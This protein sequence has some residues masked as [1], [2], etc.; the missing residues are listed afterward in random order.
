MSGYVLDYLTLV[1][2]FA[3]AG[4]EHYRLELSHLLT[5]AIS[6]GPVLIVPA[7]CLAA[8]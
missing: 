4:D 7:L 3:G 8:V 5:G 2:G 6:G 1:A